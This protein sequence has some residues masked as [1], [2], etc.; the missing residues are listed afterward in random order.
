[1]KEIIVKDAD[2]RQAASD[3]MSAFLSLIIM[4]V[5]DAVGTLTPA[6][7]A[8][9]S[10]D[11][12]TLLAWDALR[13]EVMDGGYIELIYDGYGAFI[14]RNPVAKVFRNWG[15]ETL[16]THLKHAQKPYEKYHKE[17]EQERS[18]D[19]FMALYEQMPEFDDFDDEFVEKE[20]EWTA[21]IAVYVDDHLNDFIRI[22]QSE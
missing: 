1:M 20:V 7:M 6:T 11:Q 16:A 3:G 19:E 14:F 5:K 4:A 17:I 12:L 22:D 13:E 18:D 9:L 15:I 10:A 8:E 21:R 2:L